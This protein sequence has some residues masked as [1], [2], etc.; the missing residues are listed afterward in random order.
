MMDHVYSQISE[1]P[2]VTIFAKLR[3]LMRLL[4]CSIDEM[5]VLGAFIHDASATVF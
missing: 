5:P 2:F 3:D 1:V 4:K